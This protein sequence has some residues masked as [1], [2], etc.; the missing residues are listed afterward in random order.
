MML[1]RLP[2]L[3][4]MAMLASLIVTSAHA[5]CDQ[6]ITQLT[7]KEKAYY[8]SNFP[9]LL[10]AIPKTPAGWQYND[11]SKQ[12]L[13]PGYKDYMPAEDCGPSI[14]Y[15]GLGIDYE[16]P[17]T[18]A[19]SDKETQAMQAKPD[20]A[21]QKK[22]DDLMAQQQALMQKAMA[23][24]Q[25]QDYKTVDALGKQGDALNKQITAA[26]QDLNAGRQATIDAVQWDRKATVHISINDNAGDATC[27][28]SP[29]ALQVPGAIAYQCGAPANY[30]SPGEMLD[31]AE[32]HIVVVF[33]NAQVK[34]YD[35]TRKDANDKTIKDSYVQ[36]KF[37]TNGDKS[38]A[39]H[40]LV[41][42][43]SGDDL[44]RAQSLYKQ[45]NLA[46]LASLIK[47]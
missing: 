29:K 7:A 24:A 3:A 4:L 47:K 19:D 8:S 31:S 46:P 22:L 10:A 39:V 12:K 17:M 37:N 36:I 42:E 40:N 41:V 18:Q 15:I 44:G 26:Q 9:V 14:Y 11:R 38:M 32:G 33:G 35:W 1:T 13:A 6:P 23:A 20:P 34:Q 43:V 27:Y 45:M 2:V 16:R 28:G 25:N 21:K 30:S 5:D